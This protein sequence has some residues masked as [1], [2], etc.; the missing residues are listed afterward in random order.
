[1]ITRINPGKTYP[2]IESSMKDVLDAIAGDWGT[3]MKDGLKIINIGK[4]T[5][6]QGVFGKDVQAVDIPVSLARFPAYIHD[7]NGHSCMTIVE[8]GDKFVKRPKNIVGGFSFFA[9]F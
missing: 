4:A 7:T 6:L 8:A 3:S 2:S 1:M 9:I 5:I